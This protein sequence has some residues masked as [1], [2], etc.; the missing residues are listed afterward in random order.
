MP[1]DV[2]IW[3]IQAGDHL[4]EFIPSKLDLEQRIE[5][6]LERDI[7]T[8]SDDLLVI[9]RQVAT[10]FG[11]VIDLLCL[12]SSGDT[13][14]VELKRDKTPRDIIA[15]VL[16]YATPWNGAPECMAG[17]FRTEDEVRKLSTLLHKLREGR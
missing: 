1:Q 17:Y 4:A 5:T 15:Q 6:W 7:T 8:L 2:R 12:D 11:G 3:E 14:I 13:V 10:S 9:G 16:D